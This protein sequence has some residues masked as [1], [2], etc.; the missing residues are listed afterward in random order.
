[1]NEWAVVFLGVMALTG[2]VQCA[3]VIYGALRLK[4]TGDQVADIARKF[5]GEIR[6]ALEDLRQVAVNLR[7]VSEAGREQARR[8]ESLISTTLENIETTLE[9]VRALISKPVAGLSDLAAFWDGLRKGIETYRHK[10]PGPGRRP[11]AP[12]L[13]RRSDDFDEHMFIG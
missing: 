8:V 5:D 1:M 6:P 9:D 2:V 3:F 4:A 11:A 13:S 7:A 10:T 12:P